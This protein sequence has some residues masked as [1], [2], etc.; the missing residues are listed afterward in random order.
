MKKIK[1]ETEEDVKASHK[2]DIS[3][4]QTMVSSMAAGACASLL[5]NPLDMAK[6]RMQ[7]QRAGKQ[8]GGLKTDFYYKNMFHG[9]YKISI[10]E[11][12][13]SLF[14][15]ALARIMFHIPMVAISMTLLE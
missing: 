13:L 10:E 14:N 4:W 8:G 5:T 15:G 11:G 3:F 9:I 1:R 12:I 6:L 2:E 7:V